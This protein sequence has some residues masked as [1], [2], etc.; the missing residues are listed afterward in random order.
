MD[1]RFSDIF[2]ECLAR[3]DAGATV[4]E[5]LVAFPQERAALEGSLRLA[6]RLR[7]L[8]R[9]APLPP[10][11][12]AAMAT[13]VLGQVAAQRSAI[14]GSV[15][16]GLARSTLRRLDTSAMLAGVLRALGYRGPLSLTWLR[17]ASAAIALILALVLSAGALAAAR[18]IIRVIAPPQATPV[19][20]SAAPT[21]VPAETFALDGPIEQIAP[22]SWIVSGIAV[23]IDSQTVITGTPVVGAIAHIR[24]VVPANGTLQAQRAAVE[25]QINIPLVIGPANPSS[26]N[27]PQPTPAPTPPVAVPQPTAAPAAPADPFDQLRALL[28]IGIA[29]GRAGR[30]GQ[31]LIGRLDEVRQAVAQG[32][33]NKAA[34][35]LRGL[36]D[37]LRNGARK[38]TIDPAFAQQALDGI[39]A[40]ATTYGLR[41]PSGGGNDERDDEDGDDEGGD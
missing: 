20:T 34:G 11:A 28:E 29:D 26:T 17:L 39:D 40:I 23:A 21:F 1:E 36:Q 9:P 35:Q 16:P 10:A 41:L 38:G 19:P 37:Q 24:G 8:P 18:A 3:L 12:R 4:D 6:A 22:D 13:Q 2:A 33:A 32:N 31:D 5:C 30:N 27:A 7:A 15:Q 25:V 14:T